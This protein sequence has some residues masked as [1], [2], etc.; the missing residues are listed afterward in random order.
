MQFALV[1]PIIVILAAFVAYA[2]ASL[3]HSTNTGLLGWLAHY[4]EKIP[5]FG[6]LTTAQIL[7]L[8]SWI[9]HQLGAHFKQL[10]HRAVGW[11]S[12]LSTY[13]KVVA[14]AGLNVA[15]VQWAAVSW[16]V[17]VAI[18]KQTKA[19]VAPVARTAGKALAVA[20]HAE[21]G[22]YNLSRG[23]R[24]TVKQSTVTRV[25]RVAMPHAEEW[26]WI[27]HHW[28]GL[29][30]AVTAPV[31]LPGAVA[32]PSLR[33]S[34]KEIAAWR[35]VTQA[36]LKRLELLLGLSGLA[37]GVARMLGV[38][39][40]CLKPGGNIGRVSRALCGM[41]RNFLNDLV[42]LLSDFFI[43][44]NICTVL[45]FLETVASDIGTPLVEG[46]TTIG[47]GLCPGSSAP[48]TLRGPKPSVPDLIF[49]VSASGV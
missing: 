21:E 35:K 24:V 41:P 25:E 9:T 45:P 38:R 1:V 36:R 2:Q 17:R 19:R 31:T 5:I 20:R 11:V 39:P 42:G 23:H 44:E 49:G 8:D 30:R 46:L 4:A 48:G 14:A 32:W 13:M 22:V 15:A 29:V 43:L 27:N 47:A 40:E 10:E 37:L 18:P 28:Q 7:K 12:G 34:L 26:T 3:A 6:G 33:K 16:L